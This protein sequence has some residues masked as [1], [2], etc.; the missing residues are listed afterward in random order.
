MIQALRTKLIKFTLKN[1]MNHY[2][3]VYI[4]LYTFIL[5]VYLKYNVI[6]I[7]LF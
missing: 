4:I 6:I 2:K 3:K 1:I 7:I 5:K